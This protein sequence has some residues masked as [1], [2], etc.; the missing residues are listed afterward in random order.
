MEDWEGG[1]RLGTFVGECLD[2]PGLWYAAA[3]VH[4]QNERRAL[5]TIHLEGVF[6]SERAAR[7]AALDAAREIAKRLDPEDCLARREIRS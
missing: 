2:R 1:F 7:C 3:V 5:E 4:A 6:D